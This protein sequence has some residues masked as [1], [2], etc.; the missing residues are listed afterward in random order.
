MRYPTSSVDCSSATRSSVCTCTT[1]L[2]VATSAASSGHN[3]LHLAAGG[4][5][6][7]W[8]VRGHVLL[9]LE[10]ADLAVRALLP[11][12]EHVALFLLAGDEVA[13][14]GNVALLVEGD[15][16]G[17]RVEHLAGMHHVGDL[18]G[19]E[20]LRS[21]SRLLDDLDGGV[22]VERIGLR[23]ETALFAEQL[24]NF[25][26]LRIVAWVGRGGRRPSAAP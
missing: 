4:E 25:F 17:D 10:I 19:I 18:L 23:L 11:G 5:A 16:A 24:D 9:V 6:L 20:R 3:A 26:V 8:S 15:A 14:V 12:V 7:K 13:V 21:F 2:M 1:R 22:A